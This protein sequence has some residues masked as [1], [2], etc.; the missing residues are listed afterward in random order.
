MT[1]VTVIIPTLNE[2]EF[3][4]EAIKSIAHGDDTNHEVIVSDG[5]S[6]DNTRGVAKELGA[7]VVDAQ[8]GRGTQMDIGA[9]GAR[10][11]VLVFLHADCRLP[12]GWY[13]EVISALSNKKIVGGAFSFRLSSSSFY[14]PFVALGVSIRSRLFGLPFGDQAL[15]LRSESFKELGGF[16]GLKLMEDVEIIRK[17]KKHG[18]IVILDSC[19]HVSSRRWGRLGFLSM[20]K[21]SARNWGM[22]FLY[23][24]GIPSDRLYRIYYGS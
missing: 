14:A 11:E 17:L 8:K 16:N 24:L 7:K 15:F 2:E 6:V 12:E 5:G 23:Y 13:E 4:G 1:S 19:V 21:V 20:V 9:E 18:K 3:I 22:L 10:G